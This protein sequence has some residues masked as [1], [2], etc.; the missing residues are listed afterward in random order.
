MTLISIE[1]VRRSAPSVLKL[2]VRM[3]E[4]SPQEIVR[5]VLPDQRSRRPTRSTRLSGHPGP[6][7][8]SHGRRSGR[9]LLG[10]LLDSSQHKCL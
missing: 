7:V 8:R 4:L 3:D 10:W 5:R 2:F 6:Q 9:M 1:F